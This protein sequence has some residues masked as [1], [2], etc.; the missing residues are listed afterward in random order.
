MMRGPTMIDDRPEPTNRS[1]HLVADFVKQL[2]VRRPRHLTGLHDLSRHRGRRQGDGRTDFDP[3]EA[4]GN[5]PHRSEHLTERLAIIGYPLARGGKPFN[6][7]QREGDGPA[8]LLERDSRIIDSSG[9]GGFIG[10]VDELT[11]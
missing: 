1:K 9:L 3:S 7:N 5:L 11:A 6:R 4:I 2:L 8:Q 10:H